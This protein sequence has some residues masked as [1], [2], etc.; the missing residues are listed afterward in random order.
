MNDAQNNF[1]ASDFVGDTMNFSIMLALRCMTSFNMHSSCVHEGNPGTNDVFLVS[2]GCGVNCVSLCMP[3][4]GEFINATN[5]L[6]VFSIFFT[7]DDV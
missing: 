1:A 5:P 3:R 2:C 4:R 6:L 7:L